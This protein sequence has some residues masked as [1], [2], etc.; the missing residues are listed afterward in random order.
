LFA[1]G[2]IL[3]FSKKQMDDAQTPFGPQCCAPTTQKWL[4]HYILDQIYQ[5][6]NVKVTLTYKCGNTL[7]PYWRT[8]KKKPLIL[9][10]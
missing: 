10:D 9:I 4:G 5:I 7:M 1:L 8:N 6:V 2:L 3:L